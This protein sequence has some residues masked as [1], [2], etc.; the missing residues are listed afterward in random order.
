MPKQ[1]FL[2]VDLGAESGRVM[3]GLFDGERVELHELHRFA[4][5]PAMWDGTLRWDILRLWYEIKTGLTAAA[6]RF[7]DSV[8]SVGVD[9]WGVDFVLLSKQ[10]ELLGLPY[11][12]RDARTQGMMDEAF[13][14]VPR[15]EVFANSGI[16]FMEL[17]T[18]YQLL[19]FKK[20]NPELLDAAHRFL[21][22]PDYLHWRLS[23][24]QVD[25]FTIATT[26]QFYHP[27]NH[28]WSHEMLN[29]FG[30]PGAIFPE[31]VRPG[32]RVGGLLN[33]VARETGLKNAGVVVPAAHDTGSAVAAVPTQNTGT[34]NWAY[35]SS[36]TWSLVG[37]EV[38][39]AIVNQTALDLNFTNEGGVDG[40]YRLLKNIMGLWLVQQCKRS[41]ERAGN[42]LD[43]AQ[44]TQL[45]AEAPAFRS[46]VN[47]DDARFLNPP[48][49]PEAIRAVCRETGQPEP[50]DEGQLVRCA[51]E[52]LALRYDAVI[53]SVETLT[54]VPIEVIHIVGGGTQ[55]RL[56][57]Q[58]TADACGK[59]VYTG[60]VE[61]TVL[62]N[63]LVQARASGS[64][65]SLADIRSVVRASCEMDS[66]E[67]SNADAWHEAKA[68]FAKLAG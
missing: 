26:T 23:G 60:P 13:T 44:L 5:G 62:G 64:I 2:G 37:A 50:Q 67:P 11:H 29:R 54:G 14:R 4:N 16:Q 18:L 49:M 31:V 27:A 9:T 10:N 39:N 12:Y 40:T 19:A 65:G 24:A 8:I 66:Y 22:M 32:M 52:S 58:F 61:A 53:R 46:L 17:N 35:I 47:P 7:G 56:L 20:K 57:N 3:A 51:L 41:F 68:R 36:G 38:Q 43:Y 48:D 34:P 15:D 45:A 28:D 1:C 21:L 25:E 33:E 63:V 6:D 55:N 42:S 30:I 59:P